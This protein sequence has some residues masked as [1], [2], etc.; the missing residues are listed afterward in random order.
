[1][2][3]RWRRLAASLLA[4]LAG[5]SAWLSAANL[6]VTGGDVQRVAAFPPIAMLVASMV[7]AVVAARIARLRLA[8][9]WPLAISVLIWLPYVPRQVPAAFLLW[10]GP[11]EWLVWLMVAAGLAYARLRP[12]DRPTVE[13]A[14]DILRWGPA[15]VAAALSVLAFGQV[16]AVVPSGD[17]PHYLAATQSLIGDGDLKVENNY[18]RGDYLQYFDGRLTP[19]FLQRSAAGEIYSI[20]SPGVSAIVLPA[21]LVAGYAGAVVTVVAIVALAGGL[22]WMVAYRVTRSRTAA[23]VG[24]IAV[25]GTAPFLFHTF[26]IYPDGI[27]ALPVMLGVWM[28]VR[29]IE[30]ET[31]SQPQLVATGAALALLPWLHTRFALLAL[32]LGIFII[33]L[34]VAKRSSASR[35]IAFLAVPVLAASAW[36]AYFWV[37]WGTP[38]PFAPYGRDTESSLAYVGRGLAGLALDQ[39]FGVFT[40][41]PVYAAAVAGWWAVFRR[42]RTLAIL[43]IVVAA[44]YVIAVSTYAMWWGGTSAPARFVGALLPLA[45]ISIACMW[46]VY[47]RL[48]AALLLLLLISIAL[49]IP[50]M[51]VDGGRLAFASRN[52]ADATLEWL[53]QHA[54]M[55]LA[56]PSVHRD[57]PVGAAIDALPWLIALLTVCGASHAASGTGFGRGAAWT[58]MVGGGAAMVMLAATTVWMIKETR[59]L[60]GERSILAALRGSRGWHRTFVDL[61]RP[62][63]ISQSDY[64][65]RLSLHIRPQGEAALIRAARVPAGEYEIAAADGAKGNTLAVNVNRNDPLLESTTTPFQFHLPVDVLSLGVRSEASAG[66]RIRPVR[67]TPPVNPDGRDATRAA[68]YGRARVFF[69]DERAYPEP[70]GF[71][72]RGE[73]R[74]TVVIDA[75][76]ASRQSGLRLAFTVGAAATT[77]GISVGEWSRSYSL[78]PGERREITLPPLTTDRAWV[79]EIHSG[80]GFRPFEREPGSADVRLLA[81]WF[82]IP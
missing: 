5:A 43:L 66:M 81:A 80:P 16:R 1:M 34:L 2:S 46:E 4:L 39:Q 58:A 44:P 77:I 24:F 76:A 15:L 48:R 63:A 60:T 11:T 74:A 82:E 42:Q 17:E 27:G 56:L 33:G 64:F 51:T 21:F 20:H 36:F 41:A 14:A 10:Q 37:I 59:G 30:K 73:G 68:R 49:V 55:T 19:H 50:R 62:A 18:A 72:T 35:A 71:W 29:L 52:V 26:T 25:F 3:E 53:F 54:D 13:V 69:F 23:W 9:A 12:K 31:P 75:D 61:S 40:T 57:G 22:T 8:D 6:A 78:T 7:A 38:S 67:V 70:R 79:V 47:P 28:I 32:I 65:D 45:A